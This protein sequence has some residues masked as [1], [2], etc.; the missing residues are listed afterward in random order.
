MDKQLHLS[1]FYVFINY[2]YILKAFGMHVVF[3]H[4]DKLYSDKI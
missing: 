4:I 3:G 2:I 1:Y